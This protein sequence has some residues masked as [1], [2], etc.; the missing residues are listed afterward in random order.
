MV[1]VNRLILYTSLSFLLFCGVAEAQQT[2][3][4]SLDTAASL[5]LWAIS[6]LPN[7]QWMNGLIGLLANGTLY[8]ASQQIVFCQVGT[9]SISP[10]S[11]SLPTIPSNTT[12]VFLPQTGITSIPAAAF[13]SFVQIIY[14]PNNQIT[15]VSPTAFEYANQLLYLNLA[16]NGISSLDPGVFSPMTALQY[17]NLR[18]NLL[19]GLPSTFPTA[20]AGN[21]LQFLDLSNNK[22]TFL[23]PNIFAQATALQILLLSGNSGIFQPL[24]S[25]TAFV[26]LITFDLSLNALSGPVTPLP[27]SWTSLTSLNLSHNALNSLTPW[28]FETHNNSLNAL[29]LS[30]NQ[31]TLLD[32]SSNQLTQLCGRLPFLF[33]ALLSLNFSSN[34]LTTVPATLFG[35]WTL[36]APGYSWPLY[37]LSLSNNAIR[38]LPPRLLTDSPLAIMNLQTL[39]LSS[40]LLM[41][42]D[43]EFFNTPALGSLSF[44]YLQFNFISAL[45]RLDML[46]ALTW[47]YA[48]NNRLSFFDFGNLPQ[49][50][51]QAISLM[52]RYNYEFNCDLSYNSLTSLGC[53]SNWNSTP[54]Q[55]LQWLSLAHNSISSL[56][57]PGVFLAFPNLT[58]FLASQ[59]NISIISDTFFLSATK[60]YQ[61]DLASNQL[62]QLPSNLFQ[63]ATSLGVVDLSSN[64]LT[65][66]PWTLFLTDYFDYLPVTQ[67]SLSNNALGSLSWATNPSFL[68]QLPYLRSLSVSNNRLAAVEPD[69]MS[70]LTSLQSLD[71][72]DNLLTQVSSGMFAAMSHSL[73]T[74]DLSFNRLQSL[75]DVNGAPNTSMVSFGS[76]KTL[77]LMSNAITAIS[78][79]QYVN[80]PNLTSLFLASN[81][82]SFIA[83]GFFAPSP[84]IFTLDLSG[85]QLSQ[86]PDGLFA[87]NSSLYS[88]DLSSNLP[89]TK[90]SPNL[91]VN[92][93]RLTTLS[94]AQC[95]LQS[96]P[97]SIFYPATSLTYLD[98]SGNDF[99]GNVGLPSF[100]FYN[101]TLNIS[102]PITKIS[103]ASC[104][105]TVLPDCIVMSLNN[106]VS[107]DVSGNQLS[108]LPSLIFSS[109]SLATVDLSY[110]LLTN[111]F[112]LAPNLPSLTALYLNNNNFSSVTFPAGTALKGLPAL[113]TLDLSS[114]ALAS[115]PNT[116][117]SQMT[118]LQ[119]LYL[120]GNQLTSIAAGTFEVLGSSLTHLNLAS[121][122]LTSVSTNWAALTLL[123]TLHL[124]FNKI[125][126]SSLY[127]LGSLTSMQSLYL[128][129]NNISYVDPS[130]TRVWSSISVLEMSGNPSSCQILL[131]APVKV[132]LE[133][134]SMSSTAPK[135]AQQVLSW[136]KHVTCVCA[137]GYVGLDSCVPTNDVAVGLPNFISGHSTTTLSSPL[138]VGGQA[139]IDGSAYLAGIFRQQFPILS[140]RATSKISEHLQQVASNNEFLVTVTLPINPIGAQSSLSVNNWPGSPMDFLDV[141][142]RPS[143]LT[144]KIP[145][146]M[147]A[148]ALV[149]YS[150]AQLDSIIGAQVMS[151]SN[152]KGTKLRQAG[153]LSPSSSA[154]NSQSLAL[155]RVQGPSFEIK[156]S[157]STAFNFTVDFGVNPYVNSSF[158][159]SFE[160]FESSLLAA[161]FLFQIIDESTVNTGHAQTATRSAIFVVT[162]TASISGLFTLEAV[163]TETACQETMTVATII[164]TITD[165]PADTSALARVCSSNGY[166][167][168]IGTAYDGQYE[169][170]CLPGWGG[171][172]CNTGVSA[173]IESPAAGSAKFIVAGVVIGVVVLIAVLALLVLRQ[174]RL[175]RK[176]K[177]HHIFIRCVARDMGAR[178]QDGSEVGWW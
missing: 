157:L 74:L 136:N 90:L 14:M 45:P 87:L 103:L 161:L 6:S 38:T 89:L 55:P 29:D 78:V 81:Q 101:P 43:P 143:V 121:N 134:F 162:S 15:V 172:F 104:S 26:A 113:A 25:V 37:Y 20:L 178:M 96:L 111:V 140:H 142:T 138:F 10:S 79:L 129:D 91:L 173:V 153:P 48:N 176:K 154:P 60:L 177:D 46:T 63:N 120:R 132:A 94:L 61:L 7:D 84:L 145:W 77:Y 3:L 13:D 163:A 117:F 67:L 150:T 34:E 35:G 148:F 165:C 2:P 151:P 118:A 159:L 71:L 144:F 44:L 70:M 47:L 110:N 130:M 126:G 122:A 141:E 51:P 57:C 155:N 168:D 75:F 69:E 169:C 39:D 95:G 32:L 123:N 62:T 18:S 112:E 12:V 64:A 160:A 167:L 97:E 92:C 30:S 93:P 22:L 170:N 166:C 24:F 107:L 72:S 119:A 156:S 83:A 114:T 146:V 11:T 54:P 125:T 16:N 115:I 68:S 31:L 108:A 116:F 28:E 9:L 23:D 139:T 127:T 124:E 164:C 27:S 73:I 175:R 40:N 50:S 100:L 133:A 149:P 5:P 76:L 85:N 174:H 58:W 99:Q 4:C 137:A 109:A 102:V 80:M 41:Q 105:L 52:F 152:S 36:P 1:T 33:P 56:T 21:N 8:T 66:L 98:I 17:V 53:P 82:I 19:S 128:Q 147:S 131:I 42:L 135:F 88:L 106:I 86:L 49:I 158:S 59:N 171:S 65:F